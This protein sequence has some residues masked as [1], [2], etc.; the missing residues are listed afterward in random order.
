VTDDDGRLEPQY[1][2]FSFGK[3]NTVI[4]YDSYLVNGLAYKIL[5]SI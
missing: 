4:I 3:M 2:I 1:V 5:S